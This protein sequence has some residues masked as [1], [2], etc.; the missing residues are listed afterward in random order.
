MPN[1]RYEFLLCDKDF[2]TLGALQR[3]RRRQWSRWLNAPGQAYCEVSQDDP[4]WDVLQPNF[5]ETLYKMIVKRDGTEVW[6]GTIDG[7]RPSDRDRS[8][9][10]YVGL[11]GYTKLQ[12]FASVLITP[13]SGSTTY[14]RK[15]SGTNIGSVI[16][17]LLNEC[18]AKKN[19]PLSGVGSSITNPFL[20]KNGNE[21]KLGTASQPQS[22]F[23]MDLLSTVELLAGL[24]DADFYMSIDGSTFYFQRVKGSVKENTVFK[25]IH[26]HNDNNISDYS[27]STSIYSVSNNLVGSG[28]GENLNHVVQN[29]TD[30]SSQDKFHLRE[31]VLP[32]RILENSDSLKNYLDAELRK[33][34]KP[35]EVPSIALR[36]YVTPF[37]GWDLGDVVKIRITRGVD[38]IDVNQRIIGVETYI[39]EEN[40]E[41]VK[42]YWGEPKD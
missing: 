29:V 37:D 7:K 31:L 28:S 14:E 12:D 17:T 27:V 35:V 19:S 1:P 21:V 23:M 11:I 30:S 42:V 5:K 15:F 33:R 41:T 34:K 20:D 13:D 39:S 18:A 6:R 16:S 2:N 36:N 10:N 24:G 3:A 25:Y 22:L 8:N 40:V 38:N 9:M 26:G 32:E 4:L